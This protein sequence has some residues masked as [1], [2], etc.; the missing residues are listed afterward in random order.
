MILKITYGILSR[1]T[2]IPTGTVFREL[3]LDLAFSLLSFV[4]DLK[5][6]QRRVI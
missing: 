1:G 4:T 3:D 5:R 2:G 6:N